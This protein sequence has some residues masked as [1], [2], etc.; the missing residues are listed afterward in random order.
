MRRRK[1]E[2]AS[3]VK[4]YTVKKERLPSPQLECERAGEFEGAC[5]R[6]DEGGGRAGKSEMMG[7]CAQ[8]LSDV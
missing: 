3:W 6:A 4:L 1:E 8:H 2:F 5:A 7:S